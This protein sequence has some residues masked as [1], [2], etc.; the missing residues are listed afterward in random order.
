MDKRSLCAGGNAVRHDSLMPMRKAFWLWACLL[1][2]AGCATDGAV[3]RGSEWP[4]GES[5]SDTPPGANWVIRRVLDTKSA[6]SVV[7]LPAD[8]LEH[9]G[10]EE[11]ALARAG[12]VVYLV[13][14]EAADE[15]E[16]AMAR[17][18]P[19]RGGRGGPA[20]SPSA[21]LLNPRPSREEIDARRRQVAD[22]QAVQIARKRYFEALAEARARYPNH[23]GY[24]NHHFIPLYLGGTRSGV[25]YRL[26]SYYHEAI[27]QEFRRVWPY[28]QRDTP[29][30]EKLQELLL[31]VY[32]KYPIPQLIGITP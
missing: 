17:R 26:P 23:Q 9:A 5:R 18:P 4:E 27:T 15:V 16:P 32:S 30:P 14:T 25:T 3:V 6:E 12:W 21:P 31:G 8:L 7:F 2:V 29:K 28:N 19:R 13:E 10:W 20:G 1:V 11:E 24:Q 22:H